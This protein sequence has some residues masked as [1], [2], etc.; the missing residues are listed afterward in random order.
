MRIFHNNS[1]YLTI[2]NKRPATGKHKG[3]YSY[4]VHNRGVLIGKVVYDTDNN[5]VAIMLDEGVANAWTIA[6]K[7]PAN[8]SEHIE[9][10]N[11]TL[12]E[13]LAYIEQQGSKPMITE[14]LDDNWLDAII[15]GSEITNA[16][17]DKA[18]V[19]RKFD[20]HTGLQVPV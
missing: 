4:N 18:L 14:Y 20:K 1:Y 7:I 5:L 6:N 15:V 13:W 17:L 2:S 10:F 9:F 8:I 16:W 3:H 11:I 12:D 19:M